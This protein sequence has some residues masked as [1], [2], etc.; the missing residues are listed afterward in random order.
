MPKAGNADLL[1]QEMGVWAIRSKGVSGKHIYSQLVCGAES[2]SPNITFALLWYSQRYIFCDARQAEIFA[3]LTME[4]LT[5]S[6]TGPGL[7]A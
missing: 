7:R 5:F 2:S 1:M 6:M 3:T 4:P